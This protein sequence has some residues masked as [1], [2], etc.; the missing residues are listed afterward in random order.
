MNPYRV[1]GYEIDKLAEFKDFFAIFY[2]LQYTEAIGGS[3]Q[4]V[5]FFM[6]KI[7]KLFN[8]FSEEIFGSR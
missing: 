8:F 6:K 2:L 4:Y 7:K 1:Q 5:S 3:I